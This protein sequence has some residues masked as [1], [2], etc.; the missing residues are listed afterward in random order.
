MGKLSLAE[1]KRAE[2]D[3]KLAVLDREFIYWQ[4]ES[5]SGGYRRY[6]SQIRGVML[7][8]RV[9]RDRV[10]NNLK[11]KTG[12]ALLEAAPEATRVLLGAFRV[13]EFF[14]Q[15]WI[16]RREPE[17]KKYL[18]VADEF[19]LA[20]YG[21]VLAKLKSRRPP[22]V[23]LNGGESPF[24]LNRNT[25]FHIEGENDGEFNKKNYKT[26]LSKLAF[27]VIGVPWHQLEF[28][29]ELLVVAHEVG[30]AVERD[31]E[32]EDTVEM[33]IVKAIGRSSRSAYWK[34]WRSELFADAYGCAAAGPASASALADYLANSTDELRAP[35]PSAQ[36][37][38]PPPL[39]RIDFNQACLQAAGHKIID[40]WPLIDQAPLL[41]FAEEGRRVAKAIIT[42]IKKRTGPTG[43]WLFSR[44]QRAK[45]ELRA[46][47]AK[48]LTE[49]PDER[50][51]DI[52]VLVAS[53]RSL[54]ELAPQSWN[55]PRGADKATPL[56]EIY[57]DILPLIVDEKRSHGSKMELE[58]A[59]DL[60]LGERVYDLLKQA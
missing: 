6:H 35:M 10:A 46:V 53:L 30:H 2:L 40:G 13:W 44:E 5:E 11:D 48:D 41:S 47:D 29:P 59:A 32:L 38:Y 14:R 17:L 58:D 52:R 42:L 31:L 43:T 27:P 36:D 3:S 25:E 50:I 12:D 56:G 37:K 18:D 20:C 21:P 54:F 49:R 39:L 51:S 57:G 9:V 23:Y 15:K 45:S 7:P 19:A 4:S 34:S 24:V 33:A 8:L 60:A 26:I 22:L 1:R 55:Q 16:Q 28:W